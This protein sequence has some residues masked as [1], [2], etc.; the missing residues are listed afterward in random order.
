[1]EVENIN[2]KAGKTA[3]AGCLTGLNGITLV[4]QLD[5]AIP[6]NGLDTGSIPVEGTI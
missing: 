5:R 1:M 6:S 4:A 3:L 2:K